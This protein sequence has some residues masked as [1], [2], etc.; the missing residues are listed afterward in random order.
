MKKCVL[1]D[2]IL[3]MASGPFGSN[4]KVECF[5]SSGFPIIDGANLYGVR[6]TDN[7]TKFVTEEKARSLSRSIAKRHDVIVTISG[8]L[9]Q[10]AYI[11][12][13]SLYEEYLCSQRQFRVTFDESKIDVEYLVNL[14]HTDYGQ[15]KILS[16]AN[17]V[18]VPALSQPLPNFRRI[19]LELP[20]IEKQH[21]IANIISTIDRKIALNRKRIATLEA[22][23]KEIYDY[24]FVQF[25]FPDAHGRPYKSSGGAM[26][27]NPDLKREIPKGWEV[28]RIGDHI[29]A[30]RG[31][32]YSTKDISSGNGVPM[33][34]L[35]SF[36]VDSSYKVKGIKMFD[37]EIPPTKR[38]SPYD[39]VMCNTQQTDLDPCKDIIGKS[40]LVPDIFEGTIVSSHHV[41]TIHV[42]DDN[43]KVYLNALFHTREFHAYIVGY[44]SGTSIRG[45]NFL[46]VKNCYIAVPHMPLLS[47]FANL[48][49]SCEMEKSRILRNQKM[50]QALHDFLLPLLMNGQVKIGDV[51]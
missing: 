14:L 7:V 25:D 51:E 21:E 38:I 17:Y 16:F 30:N 12:S 18:G 13:D 41:T 15:K 50:L 33:I 27:Y 47:K 42:D 40:F 24:W 10:V 48:A 32:S 11:P 2:Y 5:V 9:G 3:D 1:G 35:N 26:V 45:L 22:M 44:A 36:N 8:T 4:L 6:V 28:C 29:T 46:G 39:L 37:G 43:L 20:D 49:L 34:N 23:A 31:I 19:E